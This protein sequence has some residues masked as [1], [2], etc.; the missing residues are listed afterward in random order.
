M[1]NLTILR[2]SHDV[3]YCMALLA[4]IALAV[5]AWLHWPAVQHCYVYVKASPY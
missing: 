5:G 4:S 1:G 2:V 3:W